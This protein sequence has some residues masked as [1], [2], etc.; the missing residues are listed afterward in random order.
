M[1]DPPVY[2]IGALA[3]ILGIPAA[4]L[5]TWEERYDV[6]V[7]ARSPGG[8]RLYSQS[9]LE[10]LRFVGAQVSAG[11]STGDAHRLLQERVVDGAPLGRAEIPDGSGLT[12]LLAERDPYAADFSEYFLRRAG[13]VV[14][15]VKT[16]EQAIAETAR[17][18]LDLA[19]IDLLISGGNGLHLVAQLR[20]RL[21]VPV[22][23]IS[24]LELGDDALAA[25]AATFLRKPLQPPQLVSVIKDVLGQRA[26]VRADS[27]R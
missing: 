6:V 15:V 7:P 26:L 20:E 16:V 1:A 8:H 5:R 27:D 21:D 2:S 24:T 19:V 13:Y 4:T 12:I 14:V 18:T 9:Q 25:G 23:A 22:V 10:Q 3:R 17:K 11:L